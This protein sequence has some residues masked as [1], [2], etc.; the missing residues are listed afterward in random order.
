MTSAPVSLKRSRALPIR[1][2][3][4]TPPTTADN[5]VRRLRKLVIL[6]P[7]EKGYRGPCKPQRLVPSETLRGPSQQCQQGPRLDRCGKISGGLGLQCQRARENIR[8]RKA[9]CVSRSACSYSGASRPTTKIQEQ[10]VPDHHRFCGDS[11]DPGGAFEYSRRLVLRLAIG[12]LCVR[13]H[14]IPRI[15]WSETFVQH[16]ETASLG[17]PPLWSVSRSLFVSSQLSCLRGGGQRIDP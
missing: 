17:Q 1:V 12:V 14:G 13:D 8:I 16:S 2:D 10:P 4:P 15:L 5:V 6:P 11:A 9:F 3:F 7:P